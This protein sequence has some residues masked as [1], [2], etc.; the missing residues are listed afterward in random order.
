M[1]ISICRKVHIYLLTQKDQRNEWYVRSTSGFKRALCPY[2]IQETQRAQKSQGCNKAFGNTKRGTASIW[3]C[4]FV[5][6]ERNV[7]LFVPEQKWLPRIPHYTFHA[8]IQNCLSN[9]FLTHGDS[10]KARR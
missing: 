1:Y 3:D 10:K 4:I 2:N 8:I 9:I 5:N 7:V 6:K